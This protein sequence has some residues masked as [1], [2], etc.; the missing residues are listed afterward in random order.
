[1]FKKTVIFV[2]VIFCAQFS[3]AERCATPQEVKERL[4]SPDYDWSVSEGVTLEEILSV[5]KLYAASIENYGE[6]IACSYEAKQKYIR[7]DGVPKESSCA[8][9]TASDNW[10]SSEAGK[11]VC[12]EDDVTLCRFNHGCL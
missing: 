7:M 2:V 10:F 8:I 12:E 4:I 6:F 9:Q 5:E 1:M 11:S 3:Q